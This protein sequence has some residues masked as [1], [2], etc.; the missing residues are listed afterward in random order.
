MRPGASCAQRVLSPVVFCAQERSPVSRVFCAA[1]AID[2]LPVEATR[3]RKH[4][5]WGYEDQQPTPA[6]V[7]AAAGA[8]AEHLGMTITEVE[9]PVALELAALAPPRIV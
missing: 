6:Q 3:R 8:L 4:W 9:G 5:G 7:R 1:T 2:S